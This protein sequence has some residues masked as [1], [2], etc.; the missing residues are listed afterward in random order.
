[1][2]SSIRQLGPVIDDALEGLGHLGMGIDAVHL[3]GGDERGD[4]SPSAAAAIGS[5]EQGILAG[6]GLGSDGALNDTG[7]Y[8]YATISEEALENR[9]TVRVRTC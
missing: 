1:M 6:D 3:C 9:P 4:G 8:L 2:S 7:V 5:G